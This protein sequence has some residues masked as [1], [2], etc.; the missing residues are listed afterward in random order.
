MIN[1]EKKRVCIRFEEES[2]EK[3]NSWLG[4]IEEA[5]AELNRQ[6]EKIKELASKEQE[7]NIEATPVDFEG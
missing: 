2:F 1:T 5:T 4:S 3:L 6:V 7:V